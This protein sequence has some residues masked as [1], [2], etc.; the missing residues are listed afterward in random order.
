MKRKRRREEGESKGRGKEDAARI[1]R[2]LNLCLVTKE[3]LL[4]CSLGTAMLIHLKKNE[5]VRV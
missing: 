4:W 1:S 5:Y 3:K 2:R